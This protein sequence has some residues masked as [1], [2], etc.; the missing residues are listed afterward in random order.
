MV[1]SE[2]ADQDRTPDLTEMV[3]DPHLGRIELRNDGAELLH[4]NALRPYVHVPKPLPGAPI[5]CTV[6]WD[7]PLLTQVLALVAERKLSG[8]NSSTVDELRD[9][10]QS[11]RTG[12]EELMLGQHT[13][14]PGNDRF[15]TIARRDVSVLGAFGD[16]HMMC[17]YL[18]N[19]IKVG[20]GYTFSCAL[21][22]TNGKYFKVLRIKPQMVRRV[23]LCGSNEQALASAYYLIHFK[24]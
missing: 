8:M 19:N 17:A 13:F 14:G 10:P 18:R 24:K 20:L 3:E 1:R 4:E 16:P 2:G 21:P 11:T 6:D 12:T 7:T 15:G 5:L 22:T 23:C 9:I